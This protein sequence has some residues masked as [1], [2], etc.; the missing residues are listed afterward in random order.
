MEKMTSGRKDGDDRVA[1]ASRLLAADEPG[2]E[3]ADERDPEEEKLQH[4]HPDNRRRD[5]AASD[6]GVHR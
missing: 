4:E 3:R 1:E 2:D 6:R 5:A